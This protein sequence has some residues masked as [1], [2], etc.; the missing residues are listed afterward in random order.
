MEENL[1]LLTPIISHEFVRL[2]DVTL[3]Y[4]VAGTGRP[5]LLL[6]GFPE[7]WYSWHKVI[8]L[9]VERGFQCIA[10]DLRG[11]GDSS[12]PHSGYDK[13]TV[14]GDLHE[15]MN[16]HLGIGEYAVVGHDWG[17]TV[18][19]ALASHYESGVSHLAVL[20][21]TIPGDG[22]PDLGQGGRRWHH[23]FLQTPDL[24][25]A[26][27]F[28]KEEIFC[29]WFYEN[30]GSH[31]AVLREE[32]IQEFL[33]SYT[34]PGALRAGFAYYRAIHQDVEDNAN[35][36][37]LTIPCLAVG[38]GTGMGRGYLVEDSLRMM[39]SDV[40]GSVLNDCGHWI[41]EEKPAEL[42]SVLIDFLG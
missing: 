13:K 28:G 16:V 3:H 29:R 41:P 36:Q 17:G 31:P 24:P 23:T 14:A 20:D 2:K 22:Q 9:L 7:T 8:P 15:L 38:G 6:H 33:R 42:A 4:A 12:R 40:T 25:E 32:T 34:K 39:A 21:V 26:L 1:V 5:L 19:Y 27:V 11:L 35:Q 30:Y 18:A 10:P 37:K